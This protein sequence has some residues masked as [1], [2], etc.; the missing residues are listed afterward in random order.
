MD[1][2][3]LSEWFDGN[4]EK[5]MKQIQGKTLIIGVRDDFVV[6][7]WQQRELATMLIKSG[8]YVSPYTGVL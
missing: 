1:L 2:F 4:L 7:V 5:A 3:D 8:I 6:P